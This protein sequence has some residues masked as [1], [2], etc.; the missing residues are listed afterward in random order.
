LTEIQE[1]AFDPAGALYRG[2]EI[3]LAD[4][5]TLTD[6]LF[7]MKVHLSFSFPSVSFSV[8]EAPHLLLHYYHATK[9]RI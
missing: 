3:V 6:C 2:V 9:A 7:V 8:V 4:L 1:A 5:E